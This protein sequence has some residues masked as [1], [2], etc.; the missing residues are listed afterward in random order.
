MSTINCSVSNS[1]SL[2]QHGLLSCVELDFL[3]VSHKLLLCSPGIY[4]DPC[5]SRVCLV[6]MTSKW[7]LSEWLFEEH[8]F[9]PKIL[10]YLYE[11][12]PMDPPEGSITELIG[13]WWA[14]SVW[15]GFL[16]KILG[17]WWSILFAHRSAAWVHY[18][19]PWGLVTLQYWD[20]NPGLH[21]M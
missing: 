2:N 21:C 8:G 16:V 3:L 1:R 5:K 20:L 11:L 12:V 13:A 14:T 18:R 19:V 9:N 10:H 7:S 15:W 17:E 6:S 4:R